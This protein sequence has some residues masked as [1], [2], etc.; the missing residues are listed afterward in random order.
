V[1]DLRKSS[2]LEPLQLGDGGPV[3]DE[4]FGACVHRS[5]E[6]RIGVR[7]IAFHDVPLANVELR[8]T[9]LIGLRCSRERRG[10]RALAEIKLGDGKGPFLGLQPVGVGLELRFR[11]LARSR[12]GQE[13]IQ[14]C[15][16]VFVDFHRPQQVRRRGLEIACVVMRHAEH[17]PRDV[18]LGLQLERLAEIGDGAI[19]LAFGVL[20][21]AADDVGVGVLRIEGDGFVV[22]SDGA[23]ELALVLIGQAAEGVDG[24][25]FRIESD[26]LVVI[27]DGPIEVALALIGEAASVVSR[28]VFRIE[29][30]GLVVVGDGAIQLAFRFMRDAAVEV[31][32]VI[33][34]IEGDGFVVVGD[35]PIEVA[36]RL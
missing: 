13:S 33:L 19:E 17:S 25:V 4:G 10:R 9:L 11:R 32:G 28:R 15:V 34:R 12:S 29:G 22:V 2:G 35:G 16:C 5:P 36:L 18:I 24:G 21:G 30:D 7:S 27:G 3:F 8:F 23:V 26:G 1:R 6:R 31:G 14:H 20:G